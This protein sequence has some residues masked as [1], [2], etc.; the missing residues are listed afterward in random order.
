[1]SY[2]PGVTRF[3]PIIAQSRTPAAIVEDVIAR[4]IGQGQALDRR[5]DVRGPGA[6]AEQKNAFGAGAVP[7][8]G[9]LGAAEFVQSIA[10]L[11]RRHVYCPGDRADAIQNV[12]PDVDEH[13]ELALDEIDHLKLADGS[14]SARDLVG[15]DAGRRTTPVE[16]AEAIRQPSET[17]TGP[18]NH[19]RPVGGVDRNLGDRGRQ[20]DRPGL[21]RRR[22][23]FSCPAIG[24]PRQATD[25]RD[26]L[27][28]L[29]DIEGEILL[30]EQDV[31]VADRAGTL[32]FTLFEV[33]LVLG[34]A[35]ALVAFEQK[36]TTQ[37]K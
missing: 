7:L 16:V 12:A 29:G 28:D 27:D 19:D 9:P 13:A 15:L 36:P 18:R 33:D 34:D 4:I 3:R 6:V 37:D 30:A 2:F 22:R 5:V 23:F 25:D 1:M 31:I 21:I 11:G 20:L 17:F 24:C 8:E 10:D 26:A 32:E 35:G 14:D